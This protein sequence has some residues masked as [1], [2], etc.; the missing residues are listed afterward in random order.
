MG[1]VFLISLDTDRHG[2]VNHLPCVVEMVT[3]IVCI[4]PDKVDLSFDKRISYQVVT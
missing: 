4:Y 3:T 2:S 1:A